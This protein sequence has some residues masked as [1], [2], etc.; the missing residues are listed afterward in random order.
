MNTPKQTKLAVSIKTFF[1]EGILTRL[2]NSIFD[3]LKNFH[4]YIADDSKEISSEKRELYQGLEEKGHTIIILPFDVGLSYG[5]NEIVKRV[6]EP[7]LVYCD[8][9]YIMLANNNIDRAIG[10]LKKRKD[11]GVITGRLMIQTNPTG[12]EFEME[13]KNR[14]LYKKPLRSKWERV[15][16]LRIRQTDLGLNFFVA[17]TE[18]FKDVLWDPKL[19]ISTEH[20]DFFL[21]LQHSKWKVYYCP[22]LKAE[23]DLRIADP[24]YAKF[25]HRK[26]HWKHFVYKWGVDWCEEDGIR[27]NYHTE[28]DKW[29]SQPADINHIIFRSDDV[30]FDTD[31]KKLVQITNAFAKHGIEELYGVIPYGNHQDTET[32]KTLKDNPRL[33]QFL[34]SKVMGGHNICLHGFKHIKMEDSHYDEIIKARQ[35]LEGLLQTRIFY[36]APPFN[37]ISDHLRGRLVN[38]GGFI[39]LDKQGEDFEHYV[40]E[41]LEIRCQ[42]CWFHWWSI[43]IKKLNKWL[44]L[45]RKK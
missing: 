41:R 19:H 18:V 25:R 44:N 15:N 45:W 31:L 1:R 40:N 22:E 14:I 6:K 34:R 27:T 2:V 16:G 30:A 38:E 28:A 36:F 4:I 17:R 23:H 10:I 39:V 7:Y 33:V 35:W 26:F 32:S 37:C 29:A 11:I 21:Q 5:R 24:E 9:D 20:L 13:T 12:Y 8:D 3:H 43:D 42:Y